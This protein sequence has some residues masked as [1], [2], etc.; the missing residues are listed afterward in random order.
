MTSSTPAEGVS[1]RMDCTAFSEAALPNPSI[2]RAAV[3]SVRVSSVPAAMVCAG[4]PVP[5]LPSPAALS[6]SSTMIF[7]AVFRPS[8]LTFLSSTAVSVAR[9]LASYAGEEVESIMRAVI[10][11]TPETL[12]S[13]RKTSRSSRVAKPYSVCASSR[14]A[15][16]VYTRAEERWSSSA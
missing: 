5:V 11:P 2:V 15:K 3:A 14:T 13:S 8:A 7:W 4:E 10:P 1:F 6:F 16:W 12:T 9:M